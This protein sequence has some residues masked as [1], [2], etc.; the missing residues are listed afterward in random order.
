MHQTA[1]SSHGSIIPG[2][3]RTDQWFES[4]KNIGTEHP[5]NSNLGF[6]RN[7]YHYPYFLGPLDRTMTGPFQ[8]TYNTIYCDYMAAGLIHLINKSSAC[9]SL[10]QTFIKLFIRTNVLSELESTWITSCNPTSIPQNVFISSTDT[11]ATARIN[12]SDQPLSRIVKKANE[13]SSETSIVYGDV[14]VSDIYANLPIIPNEA[15]T[16][17]VFCWCRMWAG[18]YKFQQCTC[19]SWV[20]WLPVSVDDSAAVECDTATCQLAS[21]PVDLRSSTV[22][23]W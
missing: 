14:L 19:T 10:N 4:L 9:S 22:P 17:L 6:T 3:G 2:L 5:R 20:S 12:T 15:A 13:L 21:L 8:T 23:L 1:P 7:Y 16:V 18:I 11:A